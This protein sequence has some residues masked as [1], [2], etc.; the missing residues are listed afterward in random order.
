[1][2]ILADGRQKAGGGRQGAGGEQLCMVLKQDLVSIR[3]FDPIS[4]TMNI[5]ANKSP[6]TAIAHPHIN[7]V[8]KV[9]FIKAN[10][11]IA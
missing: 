8:T 2:P 9:P 3:F 11:S 6:L 4:G 5:H 10:R 1:M 7:G